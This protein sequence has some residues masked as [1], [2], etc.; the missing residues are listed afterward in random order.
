MKSRSRSANNTTTAEIMSCCEF[1]RNF[2]TKGCL[3]SEKQ[4]QTHW[5]DI[6]LA[7]LQRMEIRSRSENDTD[8]GEMML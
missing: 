2:I 1:V 7:M 4:S 6:N 3:A 5:A 8:V